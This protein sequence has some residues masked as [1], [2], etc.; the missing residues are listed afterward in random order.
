MFKYFFLFLIITHQVLAYSYSYIPKTL[1]PKI[2]KTLTSKKEKCTEGNKENYPSSKIGACISCPEKYIYLIN[3]ITK[4]A[5]CHLCPQ[6]TLLTKKDGYP[7]CLSNYP[8]QKGTII[9][10]NKEEEAEKIKETLNASFKTPKIIYE[11]KKVSDFRNIAPLENVCST[12][13]PDEP[14]AQNEVEKCKRIAKKNDFLCPYVEKNY[15]DVWHCKACPKNAPYK[16]KQGECFTCPYGEEIIVTSNGE[17]V[18]ASLA[19]KPERKSTHKK[20]QKKR[21][22][23]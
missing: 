1:E 7:M 8:V 14:E 13:F 22:F 3:D 11:T 15:K 10:E 4:Q 6:G 5:F 17:S 16:N 18:C 19:P 2:Y 23:R 12:N 20:N 9:A 21:L